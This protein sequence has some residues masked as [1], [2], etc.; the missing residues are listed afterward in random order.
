M[1]Q[2]GRL[3]GVIRALLPKV[4][5]SQ[6]PQLVINERQDSLKRFAVAIPPVDK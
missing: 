6:P 4:V 3:K 5:A 1:D 2:R